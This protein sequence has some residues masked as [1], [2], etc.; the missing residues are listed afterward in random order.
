MVN[1]DIIIEIIIK[2]RCNLFNEYVEQQG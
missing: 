1:F 2:L